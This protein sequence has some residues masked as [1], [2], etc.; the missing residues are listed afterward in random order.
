LGHSNVVRRRVCSDENSG[1][2]EAVFAV[3][4]AAEP[5]H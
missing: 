5:E 4:L 1:L 2:S 3:V